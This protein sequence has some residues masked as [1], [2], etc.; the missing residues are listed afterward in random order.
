L[1]ADEHAIVLN[2]KIAVE[3]GIEVGDKIELTIENR[4]STWTVVGLIL[5]IS[6]E[7]RNGF[8]PFDT[9]SRETGDVNQGTMVM[10]LADQAGSADEQTLIRNLR[11]LYIRH[12]IETAFFMS[13]NQAREQNRLQFDII[14]YLMLSMAILAAIVGSI[15]LMGTMSINVIERSK[16][17]GVMRAVGAT[18]LAIII[19]FVGEGVLLG[20]LSW[21]IAVPLSYPGAQIFSTVVGAALMNAALDFKYSLNGVILWLG[22]VV[23]ISAVSS[24]WPALHALKISV[25]EALVYE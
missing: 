13:A 21:M 14:T 6:D 15:G 23:M 24:F 20:L 2:K 9:F 5:N 7:Q 1:P 18:A 3:E 8:V 4:E 25:R 17:I 12:N 11:E 10:V 22:I 19:I 16:E